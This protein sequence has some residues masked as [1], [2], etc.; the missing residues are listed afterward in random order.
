VDRYL[1]NLGHGSGIPSK[2]LLYGMGRGSGST[3]ISN[4]ITFFS[5]T[6]TPNTGGN[7]TIVNCTFE[8]PCGPNDFTQAGVNSLNPILPNTM[9][10]FN[11]GTYPAVNG[12]NALTLNNGQSVSS[13]IADYSAPATGATRSTFNGNFNLSGNNTLDG[14]ILDNSGIAVPGVNTSGTNNLINNSQVGAILSP[15]NQGVVVN[16]GSLTIQNT[17]IYG[18]FL[19]VGGINSSL[20]LESS[21]IDAVGPNTVGVNL[22]NTN[23]QITNTQ[24]KSFGTIGTTNLV[25]VNA[26]GSSAVNILNS[27]VEASSTPAVNTVGLRTTDTAG[28]EMIGG[29]L[30]V[31]GD[32]T[33]ALFFGSNI[34]LLGVSTTINN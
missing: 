22:N 7:L 30:S 5:Q 8:N 19:G 6:G 2:T 9:F 4:S 3:L 28:I 12:V 31:S 27:A 16:S 21:T 34:S 18:T 25:G 1:A 23:T 29:S 10:Y 14:V 33:S 15:Y 24:I 17:N 13:R 26:S 11:G 20:T 32:N